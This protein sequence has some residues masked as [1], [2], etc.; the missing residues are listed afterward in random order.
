MV[1]THAH[2][3][4]SRQTTLRSWLDSLKY[5]RVRR[6]AF[7]SCFEVRSD[8]LYPTREARPSRLFHLKR[9]HFRYPEI[10]DADLHT[11]LLPL[12]RV[13]HLVRRQM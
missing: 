13:R 5:S 3:Y 11:F 7:R 2:T 4:I 8:L 6:C 1:T 12:C 10:P 9:V